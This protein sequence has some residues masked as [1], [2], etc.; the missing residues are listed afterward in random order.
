MFKTAELGQSV[1]KAEYKE[2]AP[3]LLEELQK[4]QHAMHEAGIPMVILFAGV[5]TA[6]KAETANL[7]NRWLEPRDVLSRR[8][9][10]G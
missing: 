3:E 1:S 7:L 4:A 9:D 8:R 6:G 2:R 5:D 10:V